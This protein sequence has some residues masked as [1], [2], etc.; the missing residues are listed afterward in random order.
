M[1]CYKL[2]GALHR[3]SFLS[4]PLWCVRVFA[5]VALR[6]VVEAGLLCVWSAQDGEVFEAEQGGC[7]VAR[8]L[9]RSQSSDSEELRWRHQGASLRSR[10]CSWHCQVP[11][12][13][14]SLCLLSSLSLLSSVRAVWQPLRV[15]IFSGEQPD[16]SVDYLSWCFRVL[17][18]AQLSVLLLPSPTLVQLRFAELGFYNLLLQ[19]IHP[20]ASQYF[21]LYSES[22]TVLPLPSLRLLIDLPRSGDW[23]KRDLPLSWRL[24]ELTMFFRKCPSLVYEA[25]SILQA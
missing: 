9:C 1:L 17:D 21:S 19:A 7:A 14:L 5:R 16:P 20:Q 23:G 6:R 22:Q 13:G 8:P 12:Q 10:H 25:P 11:S 3:L 4:L 15:P 2:G 18:A 24:L